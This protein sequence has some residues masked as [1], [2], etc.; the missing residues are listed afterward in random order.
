M[1]H[2]SQGIDYHKL[3]KKNLVYGIVIIILILVGFLLYYLIKENFTSDIEKVLTQESK[4]DTEFKQCLDQNDEISYLSNG[5]YD[6]CSNALS[7]LSTS[8]IDLNNDIGFGKINEVCPIDSLI[9]GSSKCLQN[10]LNSQNTSILNE[11]QLFNKSSQNLEI[12][13]MVNRFN[14]QKY[15]KNLNTLMADQKITDSVKY[16]KDNKL[17]T[18]NDPYELVIS[19]VLNPVPKPSEIPITEESIA[20]AKLQL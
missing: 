7:Q 1:K 18:S 19:N 17:K 6:K 13:K 8:N 10:R 3:F 11:N 14:L 12:N 4:Y 20:A 2:H 16:I 9:S 5:Q 15:Q